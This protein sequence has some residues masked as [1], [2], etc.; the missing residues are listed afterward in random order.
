MEKYILIFWPES[1]QLMDEEW[2]REE[3]VLHPDLDSAYF[4]PE[5]RI[6]QLLLQNFLNE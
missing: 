3:A 2:F 5:Y 4:V 1:Q 6:T